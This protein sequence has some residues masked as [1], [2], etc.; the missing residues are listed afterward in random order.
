[1]SDMF[2]P[3]GAEREKKLKKKD[4]TTLQ[5]GEYPSPKLLELLLSLERAY[6]EYGGAKNDEQDATA[7]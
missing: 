7:H 6:E 4:N 2:K 5:P 1:M 3:I